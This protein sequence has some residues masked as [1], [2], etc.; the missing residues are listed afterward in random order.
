MVEIICSRSGLKFEAEN[1]RKK[2]H[3]RIN[4]YTSH[5]DWDLRYKA[6]AVIERGKAEGWDSFEKFEAEIQK[7]L[8]PDPPPRPHYDFEGAWVARIVGSDRKYRFERDFL[9]PVDK[10]GRFKR[11]N[12]VAQ[13]D[14]IYETCYESAKGNKTRRYWR[15]ENG[16]LVQI[17]LEDVETLFPEIPEIVPASVEGCLKVNKHFP[18][19]T[20]IEHDGSIYFVVCL[21]SVDHWEDEDGI[22]GTGKY[23][24][25][26]YIVWEKTEYTAYL[27]PATESEIA[28]YQARKQAELSKK[29]AIA[30]LHQIAEMIGT[31]AEQPPRSNYPKGQQFVLRQGHF[32]ANEVLLLESDS[33]R[34]W[35][36][37]YNGRDGDDWRPNNVAGTHIGRYLTISP[38]LRAE[39]EELLKQC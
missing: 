8:H 10:E 17:S 6:V 22:G 16:E 18:E 26:S 32:Q 39:V 30:R 34:L 24:G 14:G 31:G 5:K 27:R 13:G 23:Y 2:V 9:T 35:H 4:F 11:Y 37:T 38:D 19:G 28:E 20:T 12:L 29:S 3:P 15:V 33:D 25:D 36:L 1:R 21:D 7:A